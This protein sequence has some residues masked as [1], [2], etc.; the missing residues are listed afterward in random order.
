MSV[1]TAD[2]V[3]HNKNV[4]LHLISHVTTAM[5]CFWI[6]TCVIAVISNF[7]IARGIK[8]FKIGMFFFCYFVF[9][10][11][12]ISKLCHW[13]LWK[14]CIQPLY[15]ILN[16]LYNFL[17]TVFTTV[18]FQWANDISVSKR[19]MYVTIQALHVWWSF[20]TYGI[21]PLC[22]VFISLIFFLYC[23]STSFKMLPKSAYRINGIL[24]WYWSQRN[25]NQFFS[26]M[27]SW[28]WICH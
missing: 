1:I 12:C 27:L 20:S 22:S 15:L 24:D 13:L 23:W 14:C 25:F 2:V 21:L 18:Y 28:L 9:Y 17:Y 7:L 6:W 3:K 19:T 26:Q 11:Q 4:A 16:V 5:G 8:L 10:F